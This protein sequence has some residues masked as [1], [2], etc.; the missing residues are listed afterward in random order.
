MHSGRFVFSQVMDHLPMKS[1]RKCVQRYHGNRHV[2]SFT[3]LDQFL[4]MAFASAHLPR[5]PARYR[6]LSARPS[7]Q[8]LSHGDP[9]RDVAQHARQRQSAPGLAHLCRVRTG[10]DSHRSPT[11]CRRGPGAGARQHRLRAGRVHHRPVPVGLSVGVVPLHQ[12][13]RQ[14]A[15]V[16]GPAG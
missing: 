2:Q 10:H 11:V 4:C 1:F 14:A 12:I 13:R 8:A 3:C 15:H 5:E 6:S 16:T 7:G 9:W